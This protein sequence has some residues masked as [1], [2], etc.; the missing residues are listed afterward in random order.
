MPR[1]RSA[2]TWEEFAREVGH[3]LARARA[4]KGLSQERVAHMAGITGFTYQKYEKGESRPGQP[5]NP[6]LKTLVALSQVLDVPL[7]ELLP[8]TLPDVTGGR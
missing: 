6:Q 5:L 4:A 2:P 8:S 7:T 1:R 3:H